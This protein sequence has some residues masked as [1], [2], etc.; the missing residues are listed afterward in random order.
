MKLIFG[1]LLDIPLTFSYLNSSVLDFLQ[2]F[3][4]HKNSLL[5]SVNL[6]IQPLLSMEKGHPILVQIL[7]L[8]VDNINS[9]K[10]IRNDLLVYY[11]RLL[12][13]TQC[14]GNNDEFCELM[15]KMLAQ[16]RIL[17]IEFLFLQLSI[18]NFFISL[19]SDLFY[20][21]ILGRKFD[22]PNAL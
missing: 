12:N 11:K 10:L 5:A 7:P 16:T 18:S 21:L 3:H 6:S 14:S 22:H 13:D 1:F 15:T 2:K 20:F 19:W 9:F 4:Q 8:I 17:S